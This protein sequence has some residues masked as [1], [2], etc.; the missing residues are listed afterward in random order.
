LL[1]SAA[2]PVALAIATFM[3]VAVAVILIFVVPLAMR[4]GG[5]AMIIRLSARWP[6][7][8]RR[9][10]MFLTSMFAIGYSK[11]PACCEASP[12]NMEQLV[13]ERRSAALIA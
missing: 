4:H 8:R 5:P 13:Q 6:R 11:G 3:P 7:G 10:R 2:L 12:A 9:A 1:A